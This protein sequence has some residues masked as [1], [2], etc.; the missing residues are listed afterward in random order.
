MSVHAYP[1]CVAPREQ[2][3]VSCLKTRLSSNV[4]RQVS[5]LMES[6]TMW[7]RL[8]EQQSQSPLPS[9]SLAQGLKTDVANEPVCWRFVMSFLMGWFGLVLM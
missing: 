9:D 8:V 5:H 2:Y 1:L 3:W 6:S 7:L 4:L